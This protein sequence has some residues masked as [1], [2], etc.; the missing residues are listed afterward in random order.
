ME[1]AGAVLPAMGEEPGRRCGAQAG[2][3][4]DG[5]GSE[6]H[7]WQRRGAAGWNA[8]ARQGGVRPAVLRPPWQP[9]D[10]K[11]RDEK[12]GGARWQQQGPQVDTFQWPLDEA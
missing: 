3:L 9:S 2:A 4:E 7:M 1:E 10:G 8:G 5:D 11:P 12:W 6:R